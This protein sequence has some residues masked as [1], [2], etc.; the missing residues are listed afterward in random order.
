M[1]YYYIR[2]PNSD[3]GFAEVTKDEWFAIFGT[4]DI[5]S[6]VT[7]VYK[8]KITPAEVP[9][10]LQEQVCCC[11]EARIARFGSYTEQKISTTELQAMIEE[12]M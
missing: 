5:R 9:E 12:V 10:N 3:S 11:V 4:E 7:D 8:G 6:Y 1:E 2:D